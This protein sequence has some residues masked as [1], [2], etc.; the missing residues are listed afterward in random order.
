VNTRLKELEVRR[1]WLIGYS[2]LQRDLIAISGIALSRRISQARGAGQLLKSR[3]ASVVAGVLVVRWVA[4]KVVGWF[5]QRWLKRRAV[6]GDGESR[7]V[8]IP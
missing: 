4:K 7:R 2:A 1:K 8:T 5:A 6:R 3:K